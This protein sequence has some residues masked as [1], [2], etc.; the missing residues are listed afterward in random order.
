MEQHDDDDS[1][2]GQ[3]SFIDVVCNMVGILIVLVMIVG[4]RASRPAEF[5]AAMTPKKKA[6][7]APVDNHLV[8][9]SELMKEIEEANK[10]T[11]ELEQEAEQVADLVV[12]AA[13]TEHRRQQLLLLQ[14]AVEQQIAERRAQLDEAGKAQ[15]D[16]Q[17]AIAEA[18][19]K[20]TELTQEQVSLV[21]QAPD[22]EEIECVP[23]P[24]AK[25]VGDE[26]I[27]VRLKHGLLTLVPS[28]ALMAEAMSRGGEYLRNGLRDRNAAEDVFGPIDGFRVRASVVR[29]DSLPQ[30]PT[31]VP[32]PK[33]SFLELRYT[34]L[35]VSEDI[36]QPI[37][38]AIL[39]NSQMMQVIKARRSSSP[40]IVAWVYPDSFGELRELK[41]ALW[42]EGIPLAVRALDHRQLIVFSTMGSKASAQ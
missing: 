5:D 33:Q 23:T 27:H 8:D 18:E 29:H 9:A 40:A 37:A 19:I 21:S 38:Q 16:V 26:A 2:P 10:Q 36:G 15:F 17:R 39:P 6:A 4:V 20:L 24:I 35:P 11:R 1:M 7:Q 41:R 32:Q 14:A 34:F 30:G 42:N 31:D 3:D 12:Q 28:D 22:V 25:V 13:A